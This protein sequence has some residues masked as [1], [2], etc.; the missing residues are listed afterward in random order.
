M[1]PSGLEN[2]NYRRRKLTFPFV[3]YFTDGFFSRKHFYNKK[4]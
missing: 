4:A 2:A 3:L 1:F